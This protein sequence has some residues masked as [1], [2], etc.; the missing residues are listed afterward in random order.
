MRSAA[1]CFI[2][3]GLSLFGPA[4]YEG[5]AGA[6][7][8]PG[9]VASAADLIPAW[10]HADLQ[11]WQEW[12]LV[13]RVEQVVL[14]L[15]D[16]GCA[17]FL[18][19][20]VTCEGNSPAEENLLLGLDLVAVGPEGA[21]VLVLQPQ[22]DWEEANNSDCVA[23]VLVA[24]GGEG[25]WSLQAFSAEGLTQSVLEQDQV[26]LVELP[27]PR[28]ELRVD[29]ASGQT[30][31]IRLV[32]RFLRLSAT[33]SDEQSVLLTDLPVGERLALE[34]QDES[35]VWETVLEFWLNEE[36]DSLTVELP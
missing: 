26:P 18:A 7:S 9:L 22:V 27:M 31:A 4:C 8:P 19:V 10:V 1:V 21:R 32:D 20:E 30:L 6:D 5:Q 3:F 35:G 33:R 25:L 36:G 2:L 28:G 17:L 12:Y 23:Q 13:D 29:N 11:C 24:G 34:R 15:G 14:S 16:P